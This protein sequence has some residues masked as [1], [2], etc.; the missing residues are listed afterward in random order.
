[1]IRRSDAEVLASAASVG[2][3]AW[4]CRELA[5]TAERRQQL[6]IQVLIQ[7]LFPLAV[8]AMGLAVA[9]LCLGY[10]LPLVTLIRK[11]DGPMSARRISPGS[12]TGSGRSGTR[13]GSLL[14]EMAIAAV[15]L[16]VAMALTVK[17]LGYAGQQRRSAD[18]RQRAIAGGG[19][20]HGADHGRAVRRGHGGAGP[21]AVDLARRR[22]ARCPAP[23]WPSR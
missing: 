21:P 12:A 23:S 16:T 22:P 2:N 8:I 14:L 15:M 19:Q 7:T 6:R 3:L 10:F 13:R 5:D 1:M 11:A 20:R 9:F 4:A 18:Q 17:V